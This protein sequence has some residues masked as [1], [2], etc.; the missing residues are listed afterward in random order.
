MTKKD[1]EDKVV[2]ITQVHCSTKISVA[3][4]DNLWNTF[5]YGVTAE[6]SDDSNME[7]I[8]AQLWE[9]CLVE[10]ENKMEEAKELFS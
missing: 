5:E 1:N 8:N 4:R 10:V 9:K 2:K 6:V 7:E 3:L